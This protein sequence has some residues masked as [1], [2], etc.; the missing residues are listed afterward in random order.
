MRREQA[1]GF[2]FE[3]AG[4]AKE[5]DG[6][7]FRSTNHQKWRQEAKSWTVSWLGREF[8]KNFSGPFT[9][10]ASESGDTPYTCTEGCQ[11]AIKMVK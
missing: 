11:S 1:G 10:P 9:S 3:L 8:H 6:T 7:C 4:L 2:D 5:H